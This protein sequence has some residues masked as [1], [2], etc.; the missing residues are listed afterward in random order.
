VSTLAAIIALVSLVA[1]HAQQSITSRRPLAEVSTELEGSRGQA[2]TYEDP[3]L[4][5]GEDL[6]VI[7]GTSGLGGYPREQ[8]F[9]LPKAAKSEKNLGIALHRILEA[10]DQQTSGTRFQVLSSKLGYHIV[11]LQGSVLDSPVEVAR[12]ERTA[13]EHLAAFAAAVQ[14]STGVKFRFIRNAGKSR[15][16]DQSF[17]L[18]PA[19]SSFPWGTQPAVARDVLIDLLRRSSQSLS[20]RI[21]CQAAPQAADRSCMIM[22][23]HV[24]I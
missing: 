4:T 1:V 24:G 19:S 17:A 12:Q 7:Q 13:L 15:G 21:S 22:I 3:V 20:W 2:V 11:P 16:F 5:W 14:A 23:L 9:V 8:S 18:N 10:Y 6:D